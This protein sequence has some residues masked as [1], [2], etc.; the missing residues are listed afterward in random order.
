MRFRL[1]VRDNHGFGGGV[2]Y[3][4][5]QMSVTDEAGPFV[6]SSQNES[7]TWIA[8]AFENITWDVANTDAAPVNATEVDIF[9]SADGG[10]T[11]P[12]QVAAGI[13][14]VG[15]YLLAVPDSLEGATFRV[16][17]KG[18]GNVFF[19]INNTNIT[20]E[21]PAEA[22]FDLAA[23]VADQVL[24]TAEDAVYEIN[25]S[26]LLGFNDTINLEIVSLP[27][28]LMAAFGS[29]S[30]VPPNSTTVTLSNTEALVP[31]D[32]TITIQG[33]S[34]DLTKQVDLHLT[35]LDG[36]PAPADLLSPA[37]GELDVSTL[38]SFAWEPVE[39]AESYDIEIAF[40]TEFTDLLISASEIVG[41][42][43]TPDIQLA[44]ST[45]LFWRVRAVNTICGA[46]EFSS[47]GAFETEAHRCD[48]FVSDDLPKPFDNFAFLISRVDVDRD[49]EIRD[50]NINN[51]E[52]TFNPIGDLIFRL[53]SPASTAAILIPQM[54]N[55]GVTFDIS[56]DDDAPAGPIPCPYNDGGT[57]RP[58]QPLSE[59]IGENAE[60]EWKLIIFDS[61]NEGQLSNWELEVCYKA[62]VTS[63]NKEPSAGGLF[64]IYPNPATGAVK[65]EL[66]LEASARTKARLVSLTG[67]LLQE[68]D[69][70]VL[71]AG[72]HTAEME[73]LDLPSG[74]YYVQ[75]LDGNGQVR[76]T[77][78]LVRK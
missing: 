12:I 21:Q 32:Y 22:G 24:C 4:E 61:G 66:D 44:D 18:A 20:I 48:V 46:G 49:L 56:L 19:D 78:K 31:G 13:P 67:Q 68:M 36:A 39:G 26:G 45:V 14:N 15:N 57:Y 53:N 62:P 47:A 5:M 30:I 43:F 37:E 16:K 54:C 17:V 73:L 6:V 27:E 3:D 42:E 50:L 2:D 59:F 64:T 74:M 11:Y 60:G 23:T 71:P 70:G 33:V 8:D 29:S 1:T 35:R 9:L 52:G 75:I 7:T 55:F 72:N 41:T 63:L 10:I 40:D 76:Y 28:G 51:I 58:F 38:A 25:F 65:L 34:G 69:F 77:R